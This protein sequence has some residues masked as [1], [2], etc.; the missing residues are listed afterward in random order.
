MVTGASRGLGRALAL[1][2][3]DSRTHVIALA[4]TTGGLEELDDEIRRRGGSA[5]LAPLDLSADDSLPLQH[6]FKSVHERH[7]RI[8][9]LLHAAVHAPALSPVPH[10]DAQDWDVAWAMNVRATLRIIRFA[11]PLLRLSRSGTA[12]F[13]EDTVVCGKKFHGAYG[14]SKAAQHAMVMSWLRESSKIGPRVVS[15][16]PRPMD[17]SLRRRFYPGEDRS[18]LASPSD[19]AARLLG[20]VSRPEADGEV[21]P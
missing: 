21:R 10:S 3:A 6:V 17:T 20:L 13:F 2:S 15:L 8:D 14:A 9:L 11:D 12:V 16:A 4:R 18:A 19:E 7:G 5:T 1:H